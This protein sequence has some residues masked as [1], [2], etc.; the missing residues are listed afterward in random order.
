VQIGATLVNCL[1]YIDLNPMRAGLVGRLEEYRWSSVGYP[2]QT[3][4]AGGLLSVN[5]GLQDGKELND[6]E[7]LAGGSGEVALGHCR[8]GG[9][10][11][12]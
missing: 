5:Y 2:V 11:V 10:L 1:A 12:P 8:S 6:S 3:G 4:N 9:G 7:H